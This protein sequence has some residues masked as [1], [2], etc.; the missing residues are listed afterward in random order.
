MHT[1]IHWWLSRVYANSS[2]V[3]QPFPVLDTDS[4]SLTARVCNCT[5]SVPSSISS[6]VSILTVSAP[7]HSLI[8]VSGQA[9]TVSLSV[10][11]LVS[12]LSP[13]D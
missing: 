2:L 10:S 1:E 4:L 8:R 3:S 13:S 11:K 6:T 7:R 5:R 9:T 12:I